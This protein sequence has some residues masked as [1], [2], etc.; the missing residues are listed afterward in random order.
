MKISVVPKVALAMRPKKVKEFNGKKPVQWAQVK[1]NGYFVSI[2]VDRR[3]RR[4]AIGKKEDYWEDLA[5][6]PTIG[7]LF[8]SVPPNTIIDGELFLPGGRA[9]KVITGIKRRNPTMTFKAFAVPVLRGVDYRML[10][11]DDAMKMLEANGFQ[12]PEWEE[13]SLWEDD[14]TE[15]YLERAVEQGIEGFVL[16]NSH[17]DE[18]YKV[19]PVKTVDLVISGVKW[20]DASNWLGYVGAIL[21]SAYNGDGKLVEVCSTS[22]MTMDVREEITDLED[23]GKLVGKVVEVKYQDVESHGRLQFPRFLRFRDDK[24]AEDCKLEQLQ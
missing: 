16:K 20:S 15:F 17:Y 7:K 22:G 23:A 10:P 6:H 21:C 2:M 3:K 19:K 14:L 24:P 5:K 8:R 18:W 4:W 9:T 1:E 12:V 13:V 11:F